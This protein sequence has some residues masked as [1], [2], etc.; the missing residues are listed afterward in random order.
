MW[1]NKITK[2]GRFFLGIPMIVFG[3]QHFMY[4]QFVAALV[5]TWIPG[6]LFWT[7]FSGVALLCSGVGIIINVLP[8]LAAGLL[9]FMIFT[10]IV[11]LHIPR[12][13]LFPENHSEFINVF[14]AFLMTGGALILSGTAEGKMGLGKVEVIGRRIGPYLIAIS[15][16][17]FGV[18]QLIQGKLVFIVGADPYPIP[19]SSF[20]IFLSGFVFIVAALCILFTKRSAEVAAYLGIFIIFLVAIFYIPQLFTTAYVGHALATIFKGMAMS[21]SVLVLSRSIPKLITQQSAVAV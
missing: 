9:G 3:I 14:N 20:W 19:G 5:P 15:L 10:W 8:R 16:L 13:F 11:V 18:E 6:A 12:I 2:L 21:G 17:V 4:A 7:Y 1:L